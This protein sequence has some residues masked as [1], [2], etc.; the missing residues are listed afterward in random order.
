[1]N[2]QFKNIF[3]KINQNKPPKRKLIKQNKKGECLSFI[4]CIGVAISSFGAA[5]DAA[6]GC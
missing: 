3:S 1:M 4:P 5:I 2:M 6:F